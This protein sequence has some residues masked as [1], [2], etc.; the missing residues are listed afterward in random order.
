MVRSLL[1]LALIA[2][3]Y[4]GFC[5]HLFVGLFILVSVGSIFF[6]FMIFVYIYWILSFKVPPL[7]LKCNNKMQ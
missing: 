5:S 3:I 4:K 2:R 1:G 7:A 6:H